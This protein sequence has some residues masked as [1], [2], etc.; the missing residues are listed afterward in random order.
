MSRTRKAFILDL[1]IVAFLAA[2]ASVWLIGG[3]HTTPFGIRVSMHDLDRA[4]IAT[5]VLV[6][7]RW[8]WLRGERFLRQPAERWQR[9]WAR[10]YQPGADALPSHVASH[11]WWHPILA[12]IG[13]AGIVT[14]LTRPQWLRM[15]SV[16]DLGDP[17]F[18]IWRMSWV[19]RQLAGDPR[20]FFDANIYHPTPLTLTMSDSMLLPAAAN[21]ALLDAGIGP[22]EA[23]NVL[24]LSTFFLSG[25][26]TYLLLRRLTGSSRAAFVGGL[27]YAL[28]PYRFE[29]YSHLELQMTM[30]MPLALLFLHR[31][32]E[33][34]RLRD[35]LIAALCCAAQLYSSMYYGIFILLFAAMVLG[36]WWS[37]V[38]PPWRPV[39]APVAVAGVVALVLVIPLARPYLAAQAIKGDRETYVVRYYSAEIRDYL[40]PTPRLALYGGRLL[41]DIH[42]ERALFPGVTPLVLTGL[43]LAS[44]LGPVRLAYAAGMVFSLDMSLGMKGVLYPFLYELFPPLR[45]LRSPARFS[46]V[47]AISFVVLGA[48]GVRRLLARAR[49]PR[50]RSAIFAALV[51]SVVI[52]LWPTFDL[53]PVW[54]SPPP[55]YDTLAGR[56]DVVLA[57]YPFDIPFPLVTSEVPYLYFSIWHGLPMVNGY[58]GFSPPEYDAMIKA[59]R[60]FPDDAALAALR[61]RGATHVTV[62]CALVAGDCAPILERVDQSS[63]L[64]L[65]RADT[66]RASPFVCTNCA[67][68]WASST[69]LLVT[70]E[71]VKA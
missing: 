27:L 15:D 5:V 54:A 2:I 7:V 47:M 23:Y 10:V 22:V 56:T 62:N 16:P 49:T 58:S 6:A 4:V 11:G 38:R 29:H 12:A 59:A 17:L 8:R 24:M 37:V 48:Y 65:I 71:D 18:S 46:V 68:S 39:A 14:V 53:R 34:R 13:L 20:P 33:S 50:A 3:F 19:H 57:E 64:R 28:Y 42:P 70:H 44:P 35:I 36:T 60:S 43:G 31:F 40:R 30:W 69:I 1:V 61:A 25:L 41:P 32:V 52:D 21:A 55:V 45:G 26:A 51:A 63:S 67:D 66:G 9:I